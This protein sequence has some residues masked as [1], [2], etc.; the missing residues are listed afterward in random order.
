M[1]DTRSLK[2]LDQFMDTMRSLPKE[3]VSK[4]GG[5]VKS[6]LRKG[7]VVVQKAMQ[8]N[9]RKVTR[10]TEAE[11]YTGTDT[12][13]KAIV[14]RRD[15]NPQRAGANERYRVLIA[16]GRKYGDR[17][18]KSKPV[19]AVMTGRYLEAGSENQPPE[20]WATPAYYA[21]REEALSTTETELA[22]GLERIVKKYSK[23]RA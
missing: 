12:L 19:T 13:E 22:K 20:P 4:N 15:P 1:A 10:D 9:I 21:S 7:G 2:G 5:P 18:N 11:G 6:A 23:G 8:G 16:R 3:A 17:M 14:V